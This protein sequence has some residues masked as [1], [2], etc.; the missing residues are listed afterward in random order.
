MRKRPLALRGFTLIELLV[1]V[2]II[3]LLISILLPSL[4]RARAQARTT[5]CGTRLSQLTKAVLLYADDYDE[6]PPFIGVGYDNV[7][8]VPVGN[9]Y[10]HLGPPGRNSEGYFMQFESWLI[11]G[12]YFTEDQVW[13]E[14]DWG[15]LP[16]GGPS[17]REGSLFQ[18]TGF[19]DLYRCPDFQRISDPA[20]T[21]NV[22]NYTR[23]VVG[24]KFLS[25]VLDDP[26]AV[27]ADDAALPGHILKISSIYAPAA[28]AMMLDE[29]WDFHCAGNYQD[30]GVVGLSGFMMGAESINGI[31]GDM[32]GSY[33]GVMGKELPW[34]E[35]R[36]SKMGSVGFYDGHVG[37]F[38][39]P[40]PWRDATEGNDLVTILSKVMEDLSVGTKLI[41]FLLEGIYGQRGIG[42]NAEQLGELL[43]NL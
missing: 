11:P 5:L 29:Q 39:D 10:D 7:E 22:F 15:S 8:D 13:L 23:T 3:A 19:E 26:V 41:D 17:S 12:T 18:Y 20:K 40:W 9:E 43:L 21:Q 35:L 37:L 16:N 36:E 31:I 27:A 2:A 1:V 25:N 34:D 28:M 38:R 6:T 30:P 4:S 32:V 42:L 33:H 14:P 24:R